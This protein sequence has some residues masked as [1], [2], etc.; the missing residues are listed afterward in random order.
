MRLKLRLSLAIILYLNYDFS[1]LLW[2]TT[3]LNYFTWTTALEL[4]HLNYFTWTASLKMLHFNY[5]TCTTSLTYLINSLEYL[6]LNYFPRKT[7]L[8]FHMNYFNLTMNY[9]TWTSSFKLKL[10]HS[11]VH[12]HHFSWLTWLLLETTSI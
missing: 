10:F 11:I 1:Y 6:N 12:S 2:R 5:I 7:S 8:L 4:L 9:F 3:S